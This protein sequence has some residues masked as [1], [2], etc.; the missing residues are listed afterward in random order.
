MPTWLPPMPR[1]TRSE[2][3][4]ELIDTGAFAEDRYFDVTVEYAKSSPGDIL[5][6]IEVTNR[7]PEPAS[8]DVLPDPVVP[9]YME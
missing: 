9:Q 7:G 6:R 2:F 5:I 1:R 3:E 4:Y 8:L